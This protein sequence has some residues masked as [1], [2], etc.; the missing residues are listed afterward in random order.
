MGG[1]RQQRNFAELPFRPSS[2]RLFCWERR[3]RYLLKVGSRADGRVSPSGRRVKNKSSAVYRQVGSQSWRHD[4]FRMGNNTIS[5]LTYLPSFNF[6]CLDEEFC[7]HCLSFMCSMKSWNKKIAEP[8]CWQGV[9]V[10]F[11][12]SG[13]R[14]KLKIWF[15][16]FPRSWKWPRPALPPTAGSRASGFSEV[17]SARNY[18]NF[19]TL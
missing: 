6:S 5:R 3:F 4:T 19:S 16:F 15:V 2:E 12:S 7:S 18:T 10:K 8:C 14:V 9:R 17:P 11:W 13:W 1:R